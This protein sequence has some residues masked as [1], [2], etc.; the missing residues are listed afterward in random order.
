MTVRN[1]I[2]GFTIELMRNAQL[3]VPE[4]ANEWLQSLS[5]QLKSN[6]K[7]G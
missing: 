6:V 4:Y 1:A 7:V 3:D 5:D 2:D